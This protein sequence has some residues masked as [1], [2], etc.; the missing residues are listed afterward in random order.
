MKAAAIYARVSSSQQKENNTIDSQVAA[1]LD[2]A[3]QNGYVVVPEYIFKDEGYSGAIL[4]RPG[5]DRIRD[6]SAEGQ[7]Q[8]LLVYSPDRLSRN[9]AYQIILLEEFAA[10]STEVLFFNSPKAQT[11][12]EA[13]LLQF[14]GMIA[15]YERALI[16]ER[17]RRGKRF[18]AKAGMVNVLSGAPYGYE[19][20]KKTTEMAAYYQINE[21]EAL[22][23]REIYRLY[24][25]ELLSIGAVARQLKDQKIPTRNRK[26]AWERSTIWAILRNPAYMGKACFGKTQ[27]SCRQRITKP[28][29]A[30]GGY[31]IRNSCNTEKPME[32]WIPVAVP[33]VISPQT[34]A[35]AQERLK[36]NKLH[37]QANS[38]EAS[39]L[40]GM[41]VCQECGYG[42]Y[43]TST[44]TCKRKLYY[45]RCFGSDGYRY[46]G[47]RK[48]TCLPLR[49]DYLDELVWTKVVEL[50]QDPSLIQTEIDRRIQESKNNNV[51]VHQKT[52]LLKQKAK[53]A[54][55]MD[56]LLDAYQE[57]LIPLEQL[58]KRMPQLQQR[59]N[60]TDKELSALLIGEVALNQQLQL[61][62]VS[63]FSQQLQQ[64]SAH[65]T[66]TDKRKILK[67]L[68]KD[69]VV[70]VDTVMINHSIPLKEVEK[71]E[72]KKSYQLCTRSDYPTLR[73]TLCSLFN[74]SLSV[75]SCFQPPFN[76]D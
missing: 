66:M 62:D 73:R 1:L 10:A 22:V 46:E 5:L 17:S 4:V 15:E 57:G 13:L 23:V 75:E 6:L 36:Q 2:F 63:S 8:A 53:L 25:E 16:Q 24:T 60:A 26:S 56:K 18:K 47:G 35:L 67:L 50:L 11:P 44:R 3:Q 31:S 45:Y 40:Q 30:K 58:R 27:V 64:N 32:E 76:I 34:F 12:E 69:I 39:L 54:Q 9:Y 41:L 55:A 20:K 68:V 42:L 28:L 14:Q 74:L 65:L 70:G 38:K 37:S 61:L 52:A 72:L 71:T 7:L 51:V 19:Y 21:Q 43:R 49:Q 48:C 59:A 29:R 33:A